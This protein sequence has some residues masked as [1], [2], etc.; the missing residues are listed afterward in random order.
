MP[1]GSHVQCGQ[2]LSADSAY[3]P[4][5]DKL[6][7][8]GLP[9]PESLRLSTALRVPV[10]V[11]A[12]VTLTVQLA[13]GPICEPQMFVSEKSFQ[14][15]PVILAPLKLIAVLLVLV[16]VTVCGVLFVPTFCG[17]K[18]SCAGDTLTTVP[19]PC[20]SMIWGFVEALSER[21]SRPV[22]DPGTVGLNTAERVQF[23]PG[24][25]LLPHVVL[26]SS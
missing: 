18:L 22:F 10:V 11:G 1:G 15:L 21:A 17:G 19:T 20:S 23:P 12:N 24:A 3:V 13:P 16:T 4:V 26:L 7:V 5:P 14:L 2:F 25:T 8:C 6:T 9:P